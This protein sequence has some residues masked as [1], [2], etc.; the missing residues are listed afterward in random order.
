MIKILLAVFSIVGLS[1][2]APP[3]SETAVEIMGKLQEAYR[4]EGVMLFTDRIQARAPIHDSLDAVLAD[5]I[6]SFFASPDFLSTGCRYLD[7]WF[8]QRE[9]EDL[10]RKLESAD[11]EGLAELSRV[12]AL[13]AVITRLNPLLAAYLERL[14]RSL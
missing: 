9:L 6:R 4:T 12:P 1:V 7:S 14:A 5:E 11:A 2:S 3:C 8:S 13:Q 10:L